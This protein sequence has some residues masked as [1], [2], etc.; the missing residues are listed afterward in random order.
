[1][2]KL[3]ATLKPCRYRHRGDADG[4]RGNTKRR[5]LRTTP[6]ELTGGQMLPNDLRNFRADDYYTRPSAFDLMDEEDAGLFIL[7]LVLAAVV[8]DFLGVLA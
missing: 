6:D 4:K 8:L 7:L 5:D 1:M 2:G 3:G